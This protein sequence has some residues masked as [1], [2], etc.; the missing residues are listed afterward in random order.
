MD[1]ER[2]DHVPDYD[3]DDVLKK[4]YHA[5]MY[6]LERLKEFRNNDDND[7]EIEIEIGS[8]DEND[9]QAK[10][11]TYLNHDKFTIK[12]GDKTKNVKYAS[13]TSLP[14]WLM[15]TSAVQKL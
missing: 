3:N 5:E 2:D 4:P 10:T 7:S 8:S 9:D 15:G 14:F 12:L 1:W 11:A 6:V 13:P